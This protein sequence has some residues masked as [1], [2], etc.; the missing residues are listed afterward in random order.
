MSL[1]NAFPC[2]SDFCRRVWHGVSKIL[3]PQ[4]F[5]QCQN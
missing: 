5:V 3:S 2:D 1:H 4:Y